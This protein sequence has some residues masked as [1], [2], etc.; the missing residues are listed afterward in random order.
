MAV[1]DNATVAERPAAPSAPAAAPATDGGAPGRAGDA[2]KATTETPTTPAPAAVGGADSGTG[3]GTAVSAKTD[4]QPAGTDGAGDPDAAFWERVAT[5]DPKEIAKRNRQLAHHIGHELQRERERKLPEWQ[6][7][8]KASYEADRQAQERAEK[9]RKLRDEDPEA[10]AEED[11]K[12][13]QEANARLQ[14]Q[15]NEQ[16]TRLAYIGE[17]DAKLIPEFHATLP[18]DVQVELS[19]KAFNVAG[20]DGRIDPLLSRL[21]YI[22]EANRLTLEYAKTNGAKELAAAE[23]AKQKREI[24]EGIRREMLGEVRGAERQPD[25]GSGL[26]TPFNGPMSQSEYSANKHD[27]NWRRTP[28]VRARIAAGVAA[29]LITDDR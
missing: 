28:E 3:D 18:Y 17:L 15:Q 10:F 20:P 22:K 14:Q 7:E 13:E 23:I 12:L 24:E 29:G 21:A 11:R 4:A 26:P 1:A 16:V 2:P 25:T 5:A 27:K 9:M 8:W 6:R 19:N